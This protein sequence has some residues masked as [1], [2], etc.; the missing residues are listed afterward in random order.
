MIS[1]L[2]VI[3]NSWIDIELFGNCKKWLETF[4][5]LPNGIP[6]HDTYLLHH[7]KFAKKRITQEKPILKVTKN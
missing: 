3:A 4:Y 1:L 2:A 6:S 7:I 5:N